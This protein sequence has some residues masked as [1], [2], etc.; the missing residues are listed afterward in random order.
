[1][2]VQFG[3][4]ISDPDFAQT[5]T[6]MRSSGQ[7]IAGRW[8]ENDPIL[9]PTLGVELPLEPKELVMVPEGDRV[10]GTAKFYTTIPVFTT[11]VDKQATGDRIEWHGDIYKI[12]SVKD[13]GDFG[14]YISIGV[15]V[16]GA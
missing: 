6:I 12:I 1:M 16:K 11:D 3:E 7:F 9:I 15:R 8:V 10:K 13:Y 4:L 2:P 14:A 5:F